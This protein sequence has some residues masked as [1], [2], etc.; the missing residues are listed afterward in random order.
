MRKIMQYKRNLFFILI[1]VLIILSMSFV[2][3]A[4]NS[5][6]DSGN[7]I[8]GLHVQDECAVTEENN[9]KILAEND[10]QLLGVNNNEAILGAEPT[11]LN[12][13]SGEN[14][15][16]IRNAIALATGPTIIYLNNGTYNGRITF[17]IDQQPGL[18][19]NNLKIT[20]VTII[21]YL[22]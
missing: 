4:D 1:L 3:A 10:A 5:T 2:S 18:D 14:P 11:I 16:N 20:Q 19:S 9:S 8:V 22:Q 17:D 15:D 7:E 13:Y 6:N 21:P 12:F